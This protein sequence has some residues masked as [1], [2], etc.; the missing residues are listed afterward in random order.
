MRE[1]ALLICKGCG[2]EVLK[3][4]AVFNQKAPQR[5]C[6]RLCARKAPKGKSRQPDL[7]QWFWDQVDKSG[8]C[9]TWTFRHDKYGYGF[10]RIGR[11]HIFAHRYS[12]ESSVGPI[13]DGLEIDHLC[14]NHICVNPAHLEPVTTRENQYRG[15]APN[16]LLH[17]SGRCKRGHD[18]SG[19][20]A[21][22]RPDGRIIC[23]ECDRQRHR[24]F[25]ARRRQAKKGAA[26]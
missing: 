22:L 2:V 7:M 9:W 11:R 17:L 16:M 3:P 19:I 13:P 24:E 14:R 15:Q 21:Y 26:A 18:V 6:T 1:M 12:Y 10:F 4:I 8:E 20:N 23:R 5:F 25:N